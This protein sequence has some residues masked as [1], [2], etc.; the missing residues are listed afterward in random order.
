MLFSGTR[1]RIGGSAERSCDAHMHTATW[2]CG[3]RGSFVGS[4]KPEPAGG[5]GS[6]GTLAQPLASLDGHPSEH[7]NTILLQ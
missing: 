5:G 2:G 4:E 6:V 1:S 7:V 3:L